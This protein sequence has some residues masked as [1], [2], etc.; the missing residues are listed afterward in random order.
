VSGEAPV[1]PSE[2]AILRADGGDVDG[3][4]AA[5]QEELARS[6]GA[7]SVWLALGTL[8]L[9]AGRGPEAVDAL[10]E[11][12]ELDGD[13]AV[14]RVFYA[15]ALESTGKV[16]DA[17]FQLLRAAK[18]HANDAG[19][20]RE[21]GGAFYRK[22]LHDKALQWLLKARAAA[23]SPAE[24]ARALYA[25]G[26]AQEARRDP[27]AAIAAYR[28]AVLKDPTHLD[29]RKTLVDALASMGEHERAIAVLDELLVVDPANEQA[30][31]NRE[32][33]D[34]ALGD[35]R[36]RRLV[37]KTLK[38]LEASA[39]VQA[40]QMKRR[41]R[42]V[43]GLGPK[44]DEEKARYSNA[45]AEVHAS[46][47]ED[48]TIDSILLVLTDPDKANRKKDTSFQVTVVAKDGRREP[49][50]YATAVSLTFLREGMGM[51]MT[52]AA[53]LY[54]RLLSGVESVDYGG[55]EARFAAR[56][57][58]GGSLNGLLVARPVKKA[59]TT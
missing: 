45:L 35:M 8:L 4:I 39:I 10:R 11:A 37:G 16:D 41:S 56:E 36:A 19:V 52:Q 50:S 49:A 13:V 26:L 7:L 25:L 3:A 44:E 24:E 6:D 59:G 1:S 17:I 27:G 58:S 9:R 33:L 57:A 29:A 47:A 38:E 21:V 14:A 43:F 54:A 51:P 5:L 32:A 12:V 31:L 42:A 20:L 30:A 18:L 15:R 22:G 28:E 48:R 40:G 46:L 23:A 2:A 55:L 34:R 53:E